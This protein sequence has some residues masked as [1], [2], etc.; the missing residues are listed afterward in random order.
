MMRLVKR[1]LMFGNLFEV[2]SPALVAR[3]NRALKH[4]TGKTTS[5]TEF[6]IDISGCSPEICDEFDDPLYLNPNGCNR[7]FILLSTEQKRAPILN[8]WFSTSRGILRQFIEQNDAQL[9]ALTTREAVAGEMV[10]SVY[11]VEDPAEILNIRQI[12][13]EADTVDFHLA[14][15]EDLTSKID[16]FL[17]VE[18]AWWDDVLISDM[19]ELAKRTGDITRNPVKLTNS[20]FTQDNFYTAHFDGL[21]IFRDNKK[22]TCISFGDQEKLANLPVDKLIDHTARKDIARF[23]EQND[24]V[25]PLSSAKNLDIAA[26]LKQKIDF[27]VIDTAA[28]E[29]EDLTDVSRRD[30]RYLVRKYGKQLPQE[31]HGLN[32]LLRWATNN[33]NL[34]H[35]KPDHPAY[36]YTLRS[37]HHKDKDL[38]NMLLAQLTPLDF[39]QLFICH[40]DVFYKAYRGW[41]DAKKEYV[42]RFLEEEY[43]VD[44]AGARLDL[45][46]PEPGMEIDEPET[47]LNMGPWGAI[48][49][50]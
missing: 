43:L 4:L 45:F 37:S 41:T 3:Y 40:K 48:P 49:Q 7:Q 46:G 47:D 6:H 10:N 30:I 11:S 35:I 5:L 23:L 39:R 12:E 20:K 34:P 14:A 22:T 17:A 16:R 42:S 19:I 26:V 31:Y 2:S 38:V 24:Y 25:E 21:Y 28:D 44:K 9:F 1:G 29:G 8:A 36:F 32:S 18:D 13:I 27:I 15:G 33:G 50:G